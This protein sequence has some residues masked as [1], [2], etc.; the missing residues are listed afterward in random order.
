MMLF[1]TEPYDS[2]T[3]RAAYYVKISINDFSESSWMQGKIKFSC[4]A[5][6]KRVKDYFI[7]L[8][9]KNLNSLTK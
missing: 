9:D 1:V 5:T 8:Y 4:G 3:Y 7:D 6:P 2:N